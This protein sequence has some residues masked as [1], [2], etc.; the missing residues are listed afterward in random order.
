MSWTFLKKNAII[1]V[2]TLQKSIETCFKKYFVFDGRAKRSEFWWFAL[3]CFLAGM[4]TA[5]VDVVV[6]GYTWEQYGPM[7]TIFQL[8]V[9]IYL[10]GG[11]TNPFIIFLLIPSVFSSSNLSLVT[12]SLFVFL[13]SFVIIFLTFYSKSLPAP[14]SDHFHVSPYYY[15]SIP[16]SLVIAL[17]FL[18]YFAIIFGSE[19]RLRKDAL[20]KMEEIIS[21]A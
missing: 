13:T 20:N 7:N 4:V 16:L 2:M 19:S 17:L 12:N 11:V 6:F 18:N 8:G 15:Y 21:R 14:L 3:F 5:I 10:T 9:L 1:C